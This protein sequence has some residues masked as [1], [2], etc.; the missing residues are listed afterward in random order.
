MKI[1]YQKN[2]LL[3][4]SIVVLFGSFLR[5]YNINFND[6]WSDEMVSFFL[7]N[8][9]NS[10]NETIKLIF[11]SN[12]MITFELILKYFHMIFGYDIYISRY[13]HYFL[14]LYQ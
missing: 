9:E 10:F 4:L 11:A 12:L 2:K 6:F 5:G 3:I 14:A 13:Q 1:N 8:P 7:S